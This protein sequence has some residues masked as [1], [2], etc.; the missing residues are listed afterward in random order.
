MVKYSSLEGGVKKL[1][2]GL[3]QMAVYVPLEV[4]K[5]LKNSRDPWKKQWESD[6]LRRIIREWLESKQRESMKVVEHEIEGDVL[7]EQS[8]LS[9]RGR[10][11]S[12]QVYAG[13]Q[14]HSAGRKLR[15]AYLGESRRRYGSGR[16]SGKRKTGSRG[17]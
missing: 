4:Y 16:R 13:T 6:L 7:P 15:G 14:T 5:L 9:R 17:A 11:V 10:L 2:H 12:Q 8:S 3:I 1:R